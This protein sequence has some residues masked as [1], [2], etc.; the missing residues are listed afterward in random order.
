MNPGAYMPSPLGSLINSDLKLSTP[1]AEILLFTPEA[2]S[3]QSLAP[4]P[5]QPSCFSSQNLSCL[6]R[7]YPRFQPRQQTR[8]PAVTAHSGPPFPPPPR[9]QSDQAG[10]LS[11]DTVSVPTLVPVGCSQNNSQRGPPPDPL[12]HHRPVSLLGKPT[13]HCV[14]TYYYCC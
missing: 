7:F 2:S 1:H 11:P 13:A 12:P 3:S 9:F 10:H 14:I 6:C 8:G 5:C 4:W